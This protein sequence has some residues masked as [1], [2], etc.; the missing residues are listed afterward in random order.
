MR[1]SPTT[2][3]RYLETD[4]NGVCDREALFEGYAK[5]CPVCGS[6]FKV[7]FPSMWVYRLGGKNR[8]RFYCR[9]EC[10]RTA[11]KKE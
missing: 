1:V 10:W 5:V 4:R 11:A 8:E 7:A 3:S 9:Y 2:G 6:D